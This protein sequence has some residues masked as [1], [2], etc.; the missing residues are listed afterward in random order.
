MQ[1]QKSEKLHNVSYELRGR[2]AAMADEMEMK[3]IEILRLN[4]GNPAIFGFETPKPVV[5]SLRRSM[6]LAAAY[7]NSKGILEAREAVA[8]YTLSKA[9]VGVGPEHVFTGNGVSEL[10]LAAMQ[11]LLNPGDEV[12]IPTPDYP[13]WTAACRLAGGHAVHY[14][15]DEFS[16]WYPDLD[17]I[18]KRI[19]ANTKAL[20][21]INPNNP[22][23]AVYPRGLLESIVEIARQ[24]Q[25]LLL[26]DEIYDRLVMDGH[27]HV[28]T[29][30]LAPDLPVITFNGLS[31][32]H[33]ICGFR[34]GWM[35]LSGDLK[36]M[37]SYSEGL[38]TVLSLR[39]CSNVLSQ[40]VIRAALEND[41]PLNPHIL[42]GGR[43]HR[44]R[45]FIVDALRAMPG[46]S[47]VAPQAGLYIFPKL[48]LKALG[49]K[50]DEEFV[51]R[52]LKEQHV[53]LTHGQAYNY[54]EPDH[55]RLVYL[56]EVSQLEEMLHRIQSLF[57]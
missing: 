4:T 19:N 41:T 2:I 48:N 3:G 56:P 10:I 51:Y 32:S 55:F 47:A 33:H 35:V 20:V 57:K 30:S 16:L 29:A 54:P 21:L 43:L 39:L 26:S 49:L 15:L 8:R 1:I 31:K 46:I 40:S 5:E 25:L 17:D 50:S 38:N 6:D 11:A 52:M 7:S 44:Q 23:G 24:H 42:P 37:R 53:L 22:T 27:E 12:L 9:V 13:L 34:C 36:A 18:K 28:S 14:R 45:D